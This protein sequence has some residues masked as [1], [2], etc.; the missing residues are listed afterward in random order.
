MPATPARPTQNPPRDPALKQGLALFYG[1][2]PDHAG[3]LRCFRESAEA[4][5]DEA[6][7]M[8]G[9][10]LLEGLGVA[11]D[12]VR[13]RELLERAAARGSRTARFQLG[14]ALIS[15]RGGPV[16]ERRG[17]TAYLSAAA[18]GHVEAVFNLACCLQAGV[19][20][21]PDRLAAKALFLRARTLGCTLKADVRVRQRE[22]RA[23]RALARRFED[24]DRLLFLVQERQR[25][26]AVLHDLAQSARLPARAAEMPSTPRWQGAARYAVGVLA[27]LAGTVGDRLR[28][29]SPD[30]GPTTTLLR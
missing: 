1:R 24:P 7:A 18:L 15:G 13:A 5:S 27:A 14:R 4:G 23:V 10:C 25:E 21:L 16:D 3:A 30:A 11:A 9:L 2:P 26:L 28:L 29:R 19:G 8:L 20:C 17:L 6:L 22:L 12:P